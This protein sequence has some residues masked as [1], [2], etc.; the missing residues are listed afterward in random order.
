[1]VTEILM[2]LERARESLEKALDKAREEKSEDEPF[3]SSLASAYAEVY[4]AFA[5]MRAYGKIDPKEYG[6]VEAR[7]FKT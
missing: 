6:A 3:F 5:L 1:M 4:K 2:A 7:L